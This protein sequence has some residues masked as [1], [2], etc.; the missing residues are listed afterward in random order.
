MAYSEVDDLYQEVVMDHGSNPRNMHRLDHP[1]ST[2]HGFNP[3]CGDIVDVDLSLIAKEQDLEVISA[4]GFDGK[5]CAIS[6]ASTSMMS[7]AVKGESVD[8]ANKIFADFHSMI[9]DKNIDITTY[10]NLGDLE[11][12]SGVSNYPTRIKCA[13][14]GWHTLIAA[15][16]KDQHTVQTE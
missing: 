10:K 2:A 1:S 8:Q 5:G 11:V 12:L 7:E 3:F 16:K 9:T 14:L 6:M 4:I 13:M 15:L